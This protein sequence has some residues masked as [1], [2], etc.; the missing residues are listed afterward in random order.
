MDDDIFEDDSLESRKRAK[1]EVEPAATTSAEKPKAKPASKPP[2]TKRKSQSTTTTTPQEEE[3]GYLKLVGMELGNDN[4]PIP[5]V[6]YLKQFPCT[7]SN[8]PASPSN[9][10]LSKLT[11][12]NTIKLDFNTDTGLVELQSSFSSTVIK[13]NGEVRPEVLVQ[14]HAK[15]AVEIV[16]H[17]QFYVC[18]PEVE[19]PKKSYADMVVEVL[20]QREPQA[21]TCRELAYCISQKYD[22]YTI[23]FG[24]AEKLREL[25]KACQSAISKSDKICS[26]PTGHG[27]RVQ[28][29]LG[30]KN[31][32]DL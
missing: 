31:K 15:D 8:K 10:H 12:G 30:N 7:L 9:I 29:Q 24:N 32:K 11:N 20:K 13:R 17:Y 4:E 28:Y 16:P 2:P 21:L 25:V 19:K 26:V 23:N 22:Y 3:E 14:L 27:G 5:F 18:F 6:R 1:V